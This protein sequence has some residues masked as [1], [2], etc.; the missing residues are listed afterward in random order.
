MLTSARRL[1]QRIQSSLHALAATEAPGTAS[2]SDARSSLA[3]EVR[4]APSKATIGTLDAPGD[5]SVEDGGVAIVSG[6]V[7]PVLR[8]DRVE[9]RV[10]NG[11]ANLASLFCVE[12]PDVTLALGDETF[13]LSGFLYIVDLANYEPG[14][15]ITVHVDVVGADGRTTLGQRTIV[16]GP[17]ASEVTDVHWAGIL[18]ARSV[19]SVR[20]RRPQ[21]GI[22]LLVV[23]HQLNLGGA[24]LWL[25]EILS[26]VLAE[27][28]TRCTVVTP[29]DGPLRHQLEAAG[30]EVHLIGHFPH[31][32]ALYESKV[33]ELALIASDT[34]TNV[35]LVNTLG[36]FIG[37]D[38]ARRCDIPTVFAIHEHFSFN[39]FLAAAF[40]R[41]NIDSHIRERALAALAQTTA[42]CFVAD[43]TRDIFLPQGDED[44]FFRIDYGVSL[45]TIA[46]ERAACDRDTLR[47]N[48]G[49]PE[50]ATLL[51][52]VATT[53]PRKAQSN[54]LIAVARLA[55]QHPDIRVAF[56][57]ADDS[58][59]A[60]ALRQL[61][62]VLGLE[63][64][65]FLIPLTPH[66]T[67]W[68]VM[69]D[70]FV[71]SS[72]RESLPRSIIE[73]IAHRVPVLASDAGGTSELI[74][75]GK[76]GIIYPSSDIGALTTALDRL[77]SMPGA[78]RR[79]M[80]DRAAER[81]PFERDSK[82]YTETFFRLLQG[83]ANNADTP[84]KDLLVGPTS[85]GDR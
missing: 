85:E 59:Y 77:L 11:S 73:A 63:E 50:G 57:G 82:D 53:E 30:A 75:D 29:F 20:K 72:D 80:V 1:T 8:V 31:E 19:T 51:V 28:D 17:F 26:K 5:G 61:A 56:V 39:H 47:A 42:G 21:R 24:Q 71:L 83:L 13:F 35:A 34:G 33:R 12:R 3:V 60:A 45:A 36:A 46:A 54:L 78:D 40:G 79:A 15:E 41:T 84:V 68:L 37:I 18:A 7:G 62:N 25:Q 27:P 22:N 9:V 2:I 69:A 70:A 64:Q 67:P 74:H 44:R 32:A 23:T 6:W 38:A 14:T 58:W 81:M 52:S 55:E 65:T 4:G 49:I 43:A 66:V 76:T 16:V 10:N 48:H